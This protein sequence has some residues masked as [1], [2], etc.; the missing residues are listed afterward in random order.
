MK[1]TIRQIIAQVGASGPTGPIGPTG[2]AGATGPLGPT[3]KRMRAARRKL[4]YTRYMAAKMWGFN[5]S[6]LYQWEAGNRTPRGLYKEKLEAIL[7]RLGC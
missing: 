4:G 7:E 6:T 2:P 5:E 1:T 3:I